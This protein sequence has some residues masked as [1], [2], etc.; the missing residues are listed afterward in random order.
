MEWNGLVQ[1]I[2]ETFN[3]QGCAI[4]PDFLDQQK[5][6]ELLGEA[7]NLL[8]QLDVTTHPMTVFST[9]TGEEKKH[10]GD[11]YFL[12]SGDKI[13]YFLEE[14]AVKIP[15]SNN[16]NDGS[17]NGE[18]IKPQL[19]VP[20]ERAVNKIG[21]GIHMHSKPFEGITLNE[22]VRQLARE[23][24]MVDPLVL[25]SMLIFK[26][27]EIGGEVPPHQ[28]STFLYTSPKQSAVGF[29]FA[30]EDCTLENGCLEYLPKSH[31]V[32]VT[33][34]MV[35]N[36]AGSGT[37]FIDVAS[38]TVTDRDHPTSSPS[39]DAE[40]N[41]ESEDLALQRRFGAYVPI[42][43]KRGSLVLIHGN[44]LHRSK[45]NLSPDSRWIYTFHCIDGQYDYDERNWLQ[46]T[47]ESPL[48]KL[49]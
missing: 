41:D 33:K 29:W 16:S 25:Q 20:K 7:S 5:V 47:K 27:P 11:D 4:I 37:V 12:T 26:Q 43:V 18:D 28:D 32:P 48:T 2:V 30:L 22:D 36:P 34:R 38:D 6:S 31:V 13:R 39:N 46:P 9:G 23:V 14:G 45:P 17:G 3:K 40:S 44:V 8:S 15:Q 35:R 19:L 24:G 1:E 21:H 49:F 42:P 10:I